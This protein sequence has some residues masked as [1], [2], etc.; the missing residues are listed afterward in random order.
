MYDIDADLDPINVT[1]VAT[2]GIGTLSAAT[3]F[4]AQVNGNNTAS[5][6][7]T[8]YQYAI[9]SALA[10]LVLTPATTNATGTLSITVNDQQ[11]NPGPNL[12]AQGQIG[13]TV[14]IPTGPFGVNDATSGLLE[15]SA[16]YIIDVLANDLTNGTAKAASSRS[17]SRWGAGQLSD[18]KPIR[19][20]T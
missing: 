18:L 16:S 3:F 8:G 10:T 4:G 15:G 20:M 19:L 1:V 6:S 2:G 13:V 17:L 12:S 7:I 5:L 9:N 14:A 11:H